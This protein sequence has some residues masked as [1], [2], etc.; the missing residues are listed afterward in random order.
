MSVS[1]PLPR[2]IIAA[3]FHDFKTITLLTQIQHG[4]LL[5]RLC[6]C[7]CLRICLREVNFVWVGVC[8]RKRKDTAN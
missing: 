5:V 6:G 7:V 1:S 3:N 8:V 4:M 2:V